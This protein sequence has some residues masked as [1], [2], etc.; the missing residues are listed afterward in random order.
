MNLIFESYTSKD[1]TRAAELAHVQ[2]INA[3]SN[4]FER[5]VPVR[6]GG[7]K[8]YADLIGLAADRF[9]GEVCVIANSDIAFD[10]SLEVAAEWLRN[11]ARPSLVVLSR[12]DTPTSPSMEGR[13]DHGT[14]KFFSHS[15]DTWMFVAGTLPKFDAGFTLGIPACESRLAYEAWKA[16]V[17]IANPALTVR[18]WHHHA[19][20]VRTWKLTDSYK[21]PYY[22]P[23]LT[24]LEGI[25]CEGFVLDRTGWRTRKEVVGPREP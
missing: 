7:R 13:V 16:G 11:A 23:R 9:P 5:I 19:S 17:A 20:A 18:S 10:A 8:T 25:V 4:I 15:Q 24:T 1:P 3:T 14:G 21:S 6:D 12:W 2:E 22:F